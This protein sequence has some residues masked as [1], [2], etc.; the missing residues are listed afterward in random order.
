MSSKMLVRLAS[1]SVLGLAL[2]KMS[3]RQ[4]IRG[5]LTVGLHEKQV[6][7]KKKQRRDF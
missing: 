2:E 5:R 3:G 4:P 6:K 7:K 1:D